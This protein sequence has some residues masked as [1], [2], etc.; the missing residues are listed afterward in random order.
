MWTQ[1]LMDRT[2]IISPPFLSI[3]IGQYACK[4]YACKDQQ[5]EAQLKQHIYTQSYNDSLIV[6]IVV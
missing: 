2:V 4:Q 1:I 3:Y 6:S 5:V